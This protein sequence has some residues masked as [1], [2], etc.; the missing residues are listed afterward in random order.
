M[1]KTSGAGFSTALPPGQFD[2]LAMGQNPNRSP[3]EHPNQ[4]TKIAKMGGEFTY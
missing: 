3:S 4:T 2:D 1:S